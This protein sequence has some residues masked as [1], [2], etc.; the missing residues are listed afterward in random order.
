V[1]F[2]ILESEIDG[3]HCWAVATCAC[4]LGDDQDPLIQTTVQ[5]VREA[6]GEDEL[7][8]AADT[9][10]LAKIDPTVAETFD[11]DAIKAGFRL[12]LP[13]PDQENKT[14]K[15]P[16]LRNYRSESTEMV[17]RGV[18]K[19]AHG[20]DFPSHPQRGKVN[21]NQPFLGFDGWGLLITPGSDPRLVLVQVKAT[22]DTSCPPAEAKKL[23][24]EC[25]EV[26]RDTG[27]LSRAIAV[28]AVNL[29]GTREGVVLLK[30]LEDLGKGNLPSM[31]VAPVVIRGVTTGVMADIE[32]VREIVDEFTPACA[33]GVVVSINAPLT[34][35][36]E[37]VMTLARAA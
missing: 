6:Y 37:R 17:A 12:G 14:G 31:A 22:D 36:G 10:F 20:V 18:L 9:D 21:S 15:K 30:M 28:L 34:D 13:D 24:A 8:A 35:F 32:P 4:D 3:A 1:P 7:L 29:K 5:L 11:L 25:K 16:W 27:K 33:R 2:I 26:P 19:K 23:A